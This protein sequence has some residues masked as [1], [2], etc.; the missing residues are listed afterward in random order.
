MVAN[1]ADGNPGR[2]VDLALRAAAGSVAALD[3]VLLSTFKTGMFG[4]AGAEIE[5]TDQIAE[6]LDFNDPAGPVRHIAI[7]AAYRDEA[8]VADA[9][10]SLTRQSRASR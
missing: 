2:C 10:S 5:D 1:A 4:H 7:F 3:A 9:P 6:L 8:I